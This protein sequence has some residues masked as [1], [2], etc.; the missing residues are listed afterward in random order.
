MKL[1]NDYGSYKIPYP[2]YSLKI[3]S[4]NHFS[5]SFCFSRRAY[6]SWK[7][8]LDS[9]DYCSPPGNSFAYF[10]HT[11]ARLKMPPVLV[12]KKIKDKYHSPSFPA[13]TLCI[14]QQKRMLKYY[15]LFRP[16]TAAWW[17]RIDP[18]RVRV[19][20][21]NDH[22]LDSKFCKLIWLLRERCFRE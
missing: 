10:Q 4:P 8:V 21:G 16:P 22:L 3:N 20:P 2:M 6:L 12:L 5:C 17:L 14:L 15:T 9:A 19:T 7:Q 1:L 11:D 13:E 18:C